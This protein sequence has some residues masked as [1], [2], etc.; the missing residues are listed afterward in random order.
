MGKMLFIEACCSCRYFEQ[1]D[2]TD[3]YFCTFG[4]DRKIP[5]TVDLAA[6]TPKWCPLPDWDGVDRRKK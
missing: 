6:E 3:N 1:L 4:P 5:K 2:K